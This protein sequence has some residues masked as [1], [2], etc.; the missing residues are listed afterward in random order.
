MKFNGGLTMICIANI[1]ETILALN[2]FMFA[3]G[4]F[5]YIP[6][7]LMVIL[8]VTAAVIGT[9]WLSFY[10]I[11]HGKSGYWLV[12]F[13]AMGVLNGFAGLSLLFPIFPIDPILIMIPFIFV[14]PAILY[15]VGGILIVRKT[16]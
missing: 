10:K 9:C 14:I 2:I 5:M 12:I 16:N 1:I 15:I 11:L 13:F 3:F 7:E 8:I 6:R 4:G